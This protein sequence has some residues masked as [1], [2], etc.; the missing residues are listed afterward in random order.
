[1]SAEREIDTV[2]MIVHVGVFDSRSAGDAAVR[3]LQAAGVPADRIGIL[4]K[5]TC[6]HNDFGLA[7]DPTRSRWEE[8]TAIGA[9]AG[10]VTGVSLGLAVAGGLMP[11]IGPVI[12][13]G[14]LLGLLASAGAGAAVG[15]LVGGLVGLGIP[16]CDASG[17]GEQVAA[18]R[19]L[20]A[21]RTDG[22]APRVELILRRNGGQ[23][24]QHA[25]TSAT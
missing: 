4:T 5:H 12:V 20:V 3:D 10:A 14:M 22:P 17:Y 2:D 23:A 24:H 16:E 6:P 7:D 9:T 15:T 18:G 19:T 25:I 13:G 1:M 21:V 11:P 8:G